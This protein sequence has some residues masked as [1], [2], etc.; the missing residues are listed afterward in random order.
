MHLLYE[1]LGNRFKYKTLKKGKPQKSQVERIRL[2]KSRAAYSREL[3]LRFQHF[4][5]WYE[6]HKSEFKYPLT[7]FEPNSMTI[8]GVN[9]AIRVEHGLELV[10]CVRWKNYYDEFTFAGES[11][12][13]TKHGYENG[14]IL[15]E[16]R[17]TYF[18]TQALTEHEMFEPIRNWLNKKLDSFKW[19]ALYGEDGWCS[20]S[21]KEKLDSEA[22][23]HI[24]VWLHDCDKNKL[25]VTHDN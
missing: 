23:E 19:V 13:K 5:A 7:L 6:L 10:V 18:T 12:D 21:L 1:K 20:A 11:I 24:P 25:G 3:D 16:W 2:E 15:P 9:P 22:N 17:T 4:L 8:E 14:Y